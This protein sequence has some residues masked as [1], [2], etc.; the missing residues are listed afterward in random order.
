MLMLT[1]IMGELHSREHHYGLTPK[2]R[3]MLGEVKYNFFF[4]F[5]II[6]S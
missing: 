3:D 6:E 4:S 2:G 5:F 1:H